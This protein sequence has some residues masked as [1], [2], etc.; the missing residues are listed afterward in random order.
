MNLE[1]LQKQITELSDS[2]DAMT[3]E[4]DALKARYA[5]LEELYKEEKERA[6]KAEATTVERAL[7][8]LVGRK[9]SANEKP[10][11]LKLASVNRELFEEQLAAIKD[12]PDMNLREP[13]VLPEER[14]QPRDLPQ[15]GQ[16]S[17]DRFASLV[18]R[19]AGLNS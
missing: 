14:P 17:G 9:I 3:K 8:E 5:S 7:D 19:R 4:L 10:S 15:P 11:L 16:K 18:L 1:E 6:N 13:T 2:K 12:R